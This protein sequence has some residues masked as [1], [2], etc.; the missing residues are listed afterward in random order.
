MRVTWLSG[1]NPPKFF[2][3]RIANVEERA[4]LLVEATASEGVTT[5]A[6][7]A[8]VMVAAIGK[9]IQS[10]ARRRAGERGERG[11]GMWV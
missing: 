2:S 8:E 6:M 11:I 10:R 7:D 5:A 1:F 9:G 4:F 3:F